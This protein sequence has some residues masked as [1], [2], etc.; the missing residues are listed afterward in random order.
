[1][2]RARHLVLDAALATVVATA[3]GHVGAEAPPG[4][5]CASCVPDRPWSLDLS[6]SPAWVSDDAYHFGD[7]TGLTEQ[8]A[9]LLGT[10]SGTYVGPATGYFRF[11]GFSAGPDAAAVFAEAG[12]Q[13]TWRLAVS[14]QAIPRRFYDSTVTP[15]RGN[16][17]EALTLPAGWVRA[18]TTAGMSALSRTSSPVDVRRD[19]DVLELDLR[20]RPDSRWSFLSDYRRLR[21]QGRNLSAG[22]FLANA[23][24]L[25]SPVDHTTDELTLGV[26]LHGQGWE[27]SLRYLGSFFDNGEETLTWDNPF[28]GVPGADSGRTALAPDNEAQQLALAG[29]MRLPGR[30]VVSARLAGGRMTQDEHLLPYTTNPDLQTMPLPRS[31]ADI[32]ANTASAGIRVVSSPWRRVTLEADLRFNE[33]NTAKMVN[34]WEYVVTDSLPAEFPVEN[35]GYDYQRTELSLRGEYRTS[36]ALRLEIGLD[37]RRFERTRQERARTDTERLWLRLHRRLGD[38]ADL[39][40]D[41]F[42]ERRGGSTYRNPDDSA[43]GQ[44]PVLR[45]YNMAD[46]DRYGFRVRATLY[47]FERW[48]A[49]WEVEAGRDDYDGTGIGLTG[50]RYA[51]AGV[52][53]SW[54]MGA[55]VSLFA[56]ASTERINDRQ[57]NSQAFSTPDWTASSSDRFDQVTAGLDV[58]GLIGNVDLHMEYAWSNGRGEVQTDTGGLVSE[59]PD[60]TSR[61]QTFSVGLEYAPGDAWSYGLDA[62]HEKVVSDD[63]ALDGVGPSTVPNL[64]S[65]GAEAF[66]YDVTV[67]SLTVRYRH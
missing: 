58:P 33:L 45:K 28:T 37:A 38:G 29:S 39:D 36:R 19:V 63:W 27:A 43:A 50:S 1:M 56:S 59:F 9:Y 48:E 20:I 57:S 61:R 46:R 18:P 40:F 2:R 35:P 66:N 24:A 34:A 54:L 3:A 5:R 21:R 26:A 14:Y 16:G 30:T 41:L 4:W 47:P 65:V 42:G 17:G 51:R 25:V 49:G 6:A 60:L 10:F 11:D 67:V 53:F 64:L 52:D 32:R 7:Y 22:S 55:G 44:N 23:E 13:S 15:Y 62:Y 8:G 31:R 12:Q